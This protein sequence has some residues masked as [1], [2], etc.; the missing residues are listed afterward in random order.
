[1]IYKLKYNLNIYK[2]SYKHSYYK[3]FISLFSYLINL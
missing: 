1:M 3:I 2:F